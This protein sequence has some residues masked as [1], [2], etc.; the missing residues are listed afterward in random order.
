MK[1]EHCSN[2]N[3]VKLRISDLML[4]SQC[5]KIEKHKCQMAQ[6]EKTFLNDDKSTS[7]IRNLLGIV[8]DLVN[9]IE[10]LSKKVQYLTDENEALKCEIVEIKNELRPKTNIEADESFAT[11]S[12]NDSQWVTVSRGRKSQH[13]KKKEKSTDNSFQMPIPKENQLNVCK[14]LKSSEHLNKVKVLK[15]SVANN[16]CSEIYIGG[17]DIGND[18]KDIKE[19]LDGKGIKTMDIVQLKATPAKSFCL[20][21]KNPDCNKALMQENW[22]AGIKVQRFRHT[23]TNKINH[24][25]VYPEYRPNVNLGHYEQGNQGYPK[26]CWNCGEF[27]HTKSTCRHQQKIRC[28]NCLELGHKAKFCYQ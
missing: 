9:N 26:C 24:F 23:K 28:G 14:P 15:A 19:H 13:E 16:D 5:D 2:Y 20:K 17:V 7:S 4:C 12:P 25:S 27:N 21:V 11:I 18:A 8:N 22:P 6:M 1:C 3:N 10:C